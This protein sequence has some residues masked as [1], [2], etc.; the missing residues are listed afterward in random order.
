[1]SVIIYKDNNKDELLEKVKEKKNANAPNNCNA[2][3]FSLRCLYFHQRLLTKLSK[4]KGI[5]VFCVYLVFANATL[6]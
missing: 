6:R 4:L 3:I 5:L 2:Y 1:M